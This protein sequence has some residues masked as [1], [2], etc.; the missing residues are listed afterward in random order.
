MKNKNKRLKNITTKNNKLRIKIINGAL[1][2]Q[3]KKI[4]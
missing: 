1:K 2:I 3:N 4:H